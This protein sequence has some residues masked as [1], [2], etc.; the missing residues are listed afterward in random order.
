MEASVPLRVMVSG[1]FDPLHGGHIEY[2]RL[3]AQFGQVIVALNSDAWLVKK[4]GY[5]FMGWEERRRV[6]ESLKYV[7]EV[8]AVDDAD[9]TVNEA[10]L[11][12]RPDVF[13]NGGDR[14]P[15]N[16][17][18]TEVCKTLG[19]ATLFNLGAKV[20]S[21]S[22]LVSKSK[23]VQREWGT[24]DVLWE[25]PGVKVKAMRIRPGQETSMQRHAL[26]DEYWFFADGKRKYLKAGEWHQLRNE[27][28]QEMA[29]IEVQT[30]ICEE[31]DIQRLDGRHMS[32]ADAWEASLQA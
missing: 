11:R 27:D 32:E 6:L 14:G 5:V 25:S 31:D 18:E 17:P 4:K 23:T 2:L 8:L 26:R 9:G 7:H 3:A 22:W 20:Q 28:D 15:S 30:G 10:I 16:I 21:S 24:Y 12:C 13:A 29:V 19:I 1:G